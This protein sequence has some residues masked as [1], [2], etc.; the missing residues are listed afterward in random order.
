M[1]FFACLIRARPSSS[2]HQSLT[3]RR[4]PP[5]PPPTWNAWLVALHEASL[6]SRFTQQKRLQ[7]IPVLVLCDRPPLLRMSG[8]TSVGD[9][10]VRILIFFFFFV[11][12]YPPFCFKVSSSGFFLFSGHSFCLFSAYMYPHVSSS[13]L[14]K[15]S[16]RCTSYGPSSDIV[17][18]HSQQDRLC[19]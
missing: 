15:C 18:S 9:E 3:Q 11:Q 16:L 1:T 10:G 8:R 17:E 2:G 6:R 5:L 12:P 13:N 4:I 7:Q 19:Q 14:M